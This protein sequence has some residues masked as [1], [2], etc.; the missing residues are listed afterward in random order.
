M[1]KYIA[2]PAVEEHLSDVEKGSLADLKKKILQL[3]KEVPETSL[4]VIIKK[5]KE[6]EDEL[7]EA[8]KENKAKKLEGG[9]EFE[10]DS[11][12]ASDDE[13]YERKK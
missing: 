12:P 3:R 6:K 2:L 13:E 10:D 1:S 8:F 7:I 4:E 11:Y 5:G 9:F